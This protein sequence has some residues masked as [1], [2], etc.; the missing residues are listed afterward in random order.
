MKSGSRH[1]LTAGIVVG[2]L[3][4]GAGIF[5]WSGLYNIGADDPHWM[6]TR[7]AI[8]S[9]RERSI[10]ARMAD[11]QVPDL[12]DPKRI[13][14]GALN[15]SAMCTGCHLAPGVTDSEIRPGL[16]PTPPN[17]SKL[18]AADVKRTFW[19]IKHGIKMSA[20]PAWGKTHTDEQMWDMTVFIRKMPGMTAVQYQSLGGKPPEEDEDHMH[21][22]TEGGH[23][24]MDMPE[25]GA[26]E[27]HAHD[28][29]TPADHHASRMAPADSEPVEHR[30]ADGTVESHAAEQHPPPQPA[31]PHAGMQMPAMPDTGQ[32]NEGQP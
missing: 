27:L 4:I 5:I 31:D 28:H 14:A 20:M 25:T 6:P 10:A 18:G 16:Y 2:V 29:A 11:V 22:G 32:P 12:D 26:D 19:I 24:A 1:I 8:D 13:A 23:A 30:H 21:A 9:L 17:L 7:M 3:V 15:Y